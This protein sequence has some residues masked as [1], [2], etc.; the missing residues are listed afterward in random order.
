VNWTDSQ[1]TA[2]V[3]NCTYL[4][5]NGAFAAS[6]FKRRRVDALTLKAFRLLCANFYTAFWCSITEHYYCGET[7]VYGYTTY[8]YSSGVATCPFYRFWLIYAT[9]DVAD[10]YMFYRCFYSV[11]FLSL[12]FVFVFFRSVKNTRQPFSGTAERISIKLL[13]N[14]SGE[15]VVSNIVPKWG[16]GPKIIFAGYIYTLRTWWWRLASDWE[17]VCWLWHCAA[18]AVALQRHERANAFNLVA[19]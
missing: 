7:H 14:D 13:P 19:N 18:T 5:A 15:N 9:A 12:F 10:A 1:I 4:P 16:L 17:L 11:F 8:I 3:Q 2:S 6:D